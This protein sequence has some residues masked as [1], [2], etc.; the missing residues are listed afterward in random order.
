[1]ET[2]RV[3]EEDLVAIGQSITDKKFTLTVQLL[4][5]IEILDNLW[6]TNFLVLALE[7]HTTKEVVET[8][9][10]KGASV[11]PIE[12]VRVAPLNLATFKGNTT[13][14]ILSLLME[15]GADVNYDYGVGTSPI[16]LMT[17]T[18]SST[19]GMIAC[20][21]KHGLKY[22]PGF[23]MHIHPDKR[24]VGYFMQVYFRVFP[25]FVSKKVSSE[26]PRIL[27]SFLYKID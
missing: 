23:L 27:F 20:M 17:L 1:M 13:N 19:N 26:F 18:N 5:D 3:T 11:N 22:H 8:L 4:Q 10:D 14:G 16:T 9:I 15:K 7:N 21:L 6:A 2:T 12:G 24:K 25:Y